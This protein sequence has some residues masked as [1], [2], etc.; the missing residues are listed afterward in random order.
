L[1]DPAVLPNLTDWVK[2]GFVFLSRRSP[3]GEA[4]FIVFT[5]YKRAYICLAAN[6]SGRIDELALF[7]KKG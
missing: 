2:I 4:G 3:M 7:F 5:C 1:S 6:L